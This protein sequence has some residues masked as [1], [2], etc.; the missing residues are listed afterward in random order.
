MYLVKCSIILKI[1]KI[2]LLPTLDLYSFPLETSTVT[3]FCQS[4]QKLFRLTQVS[5][6]WIL[7]TKLGIR[8]IKLSLFANDMTEY[9]EFQWIYQ[10]ET[11]EDK[12]FY[13]LCRIKGQIQ[14]TLWALFSEIS[15]LI[16]YFAGAA[17]SNYYK[18]FYHLF[19][20]FILLSSWIGNKN[21]MDWDQPT[22]HCPH[23]TQTFIN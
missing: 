8:E 2:N 11:R 19:L 3:S 12:W 10:K 7:S 21:F 5:Q 13:Q 20:N 6:L 9:K 14:N 4:F 16:T 1:I 23:D 22:D 18:C 17:M 15:V